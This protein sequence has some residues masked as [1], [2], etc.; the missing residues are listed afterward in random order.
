MVSHDVYDKAG[1]I[2]MC[3][4]F[5]IIRSGESY[6]AD[7]S[8]AASMRDAI[9]HRG[10]D[11]SGV[12]IEPGAMLGNNRL[13]IMD[14]EFGNQPI[15]NETG[16]LLIVY[17]GEVFNHQDIRMM[18]EDRGHV[19]KSRSDTETVLHAYEEYG[20]KCVDMFNGMFSFAVWDKRKRRLFLA[21]DRL[22]VKPLYTM[23]LPGGGFAFASEAKALLP[24]VTGRPQPDWTALYRYFTFGYVP[25]DESPF[26]GIEKFPPGHFA[27]LENGTF[28]TESYWKPE[29]GLGESRDM[30]AASEKILELMEEAVTLELM[31]DVDLGVFLS[32]G[33][34][35]SAIAYFA[36]KKSKSRIHSFSLGFEE[37]THDESDD[38]AAVAEHLGLE[39]HKL[40]FTNDVMMSSFKKVSDIL[41]EP[42]ADCTVLPLYAISELA[43][44][45]VKV[46]LTGW[47]GDEIFAGYPTYK[48]HLMSRSYRK[49]PA[50]IGEGLIPRFVNSLPVSDKYMSFEFKAKRFVRGM[51]LSP[52]L[53]HFTWMGY[54]DDAG[55]KRLFKE[56]ILEKVGGDTFDPVVRELGIMNET[57]IISRIMRLDA[58]FFLRG[59]GLFQADRITMAASLEARVPLLNINLLEYMNRLPASI[60]MCGS[61]PK[62]LMRL[63][64]SGMLPPRIIR[65]AKKGFGPPAA[66]WTRGPFLNILKSVFDREKVE[67]AGI[68]SWEEISR[69]TSEHESRGADHGRNLWALLSFQMWYDRFIA[70]CNY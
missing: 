34:D 60:K 70:T 42:F 67:E 51:Q 53:Q 17:N 50:W 35:S 38:A 52:E 24:L 23:R 68:F 9:K 33:L 5:G 45:H 49:L 7:E 37:A 25:A 8:A 62:G 10:P 13:A 29:Y 66:A 47:G 20:S 61:N 56:S 28:E 26:M 3:G 55:K 48:A 40:L 14:V 54:F 15:F 22:G 16:E 65:K 44:R 30:R 59:N 39:H 46:V 21:C 64:L 57:E 58:A 43:A 41:D 19:F 63:A 18:L 32:G 6:G 31:S 2:D 4:I 11:S 27:S 12:F 1:Q 36:A 69:L